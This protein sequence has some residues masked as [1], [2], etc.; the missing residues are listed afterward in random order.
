RL[1]SAVGRARHI[2]SY[3]LPNARL[4]RLQGY[5]EFIPVQR[6]H[7][8]TLCE[9]ATFFISIGILRRMST[10]FNGRVVYHRHWDVFFQDIRS[11]WLKTSGVSGLI[12]LCDV[13]LMAS[14]LNNIATSASASLGGASI[15]IGIFLHQK[16][17]QWQLATGPD[18]VSPIIRSVR[19]R[20]NESIAQ[21][22][23]VMSV[24]DYWQGLRPLSIVLALPQAVSIYSALLFHLGLLLIVT[25]RIAQAQEAVWTMAA[26]WVGI[27]PLAA[28]V[29]FF[30]PPKPESPKPE[31]QNQNPGLLKSVLR[32]WKERP[33]REGNA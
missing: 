29:M 32:K 6:S 30:A 15:F 7:T 10:L 19:V 5:T 22:Q 8:M 9:S 2:N 24:E 18:I 14:K 26:M 21:S 27:L 11:T 23:Y 16:H 28:S 3:G 12:L 4:D 33:A 1:W 25:D 20:A 31:L 13:A 17:P